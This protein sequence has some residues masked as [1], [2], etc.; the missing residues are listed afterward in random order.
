[1]F[2]WRKRKEGFEWHKYVRTT[3]KLRRDARRE[4]ADQLKRQAA[5][6][7]K[8]AGAVAGDAARASARKLGASSR[9]A[10]AVAGSWLGTLGRWLAA[11]AGRLMRALVDLLSRVKASRL[12]IPAAMA[13]LGPR[14]RPV[15][16]AVMGVVGLAIV[17]A[18]A[19]LAGLN[20][21]R[22]AGVPSNPFAKSVR[23]VEGKATVLGPGTLK[24]GATTIALAEIEAPEKDQRC[25]KS[26]N[27]R[28]RCG[29]AAVAALGKL[30][31]GR[32][33]RCEVRA[34]EAPDA[35]AAICFDKDTDINAALVKGGHV[36]AVSGM[37]SRYGSLESEAR[38]AKAGLWAGD[39]E[40]PA[41]Y[42]ARMWEEAKRR[43]PDGCP[44]KGQVTGGSRSYVMPWSPDYERVKVNTARGGRWFCTE[45]EAMAAGWKVKLASGI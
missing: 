26:G 32:A 21:Q 28:W 38:N 31:N 6:G 43:A 45:Q 35:V 25:A 3:I 27:R 8:A 22:F 10:A 44:I 2:F 1:M 15:A 14:G 7:V 41:A 18:L 17:S 9:F 30:A 11:T 39:G 40:R 29:E 16:F 33:L 23:L 12:G 13:K 4:K 20:V 37:F 34:T 5:D 36:F 24:I 19:G 42:R